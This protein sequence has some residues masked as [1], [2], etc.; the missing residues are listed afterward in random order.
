MKA[1]GGEV[2]F[3]T[4][5]SNCQRLSVIRLNEQIVRHDE[6]KYASLLCSFGTRLI[7][8]EIGCLSDEN[9]KK[10]TTARTNLQIGYYRIPH[11]PES[12]E[13][14]RVCIMAPFLEKLNIH[15]YSFYN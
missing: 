2:I 1:G 4:I 3:D 10:V 9:L 5:K 12:G 14:N 15:C 13:R 8:A 11:G 7:K 6:N